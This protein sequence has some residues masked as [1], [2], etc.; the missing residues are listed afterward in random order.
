[1]SSGWEADTPS[2]R[3]KGAFTLERLPREQ[4]GPFL[5]LGVPKTASAEQIDASWA[6][7]LKW[8]RQKIVT[9]PLEDI[10]WAREM[11]KEEGKRIEWDAGSLNI[12]VTEG[13]L[14]RLEARYGGAAANK[15]TCTPIDE[16]KSLADYTPD[17]ELPHEE[18]IRE[19]IVVP[20]IPRE[21][22][23]VHHLLQEF[24]ATPMDPWEVDLPE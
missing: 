20:E 23:A 1:M 17:V 4:V 14:Q 12:D 21:F 8:A 16:E 22:P 6:Q 9:V 2:P 10:N 19:S 18:E 3:A 7:R 24:V 13:V 11:L 15:V 5:L